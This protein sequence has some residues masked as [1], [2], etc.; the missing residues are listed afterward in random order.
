MEDRLKVSNSI[1]FSL[2]DFPISSNDAN[3]PHSTYIHVTVTLNEVCCKM[4][5]YLHTIYI[6]K[7]FDDDHFL[8]FLK[9]A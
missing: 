6:G 3:L 9:S 5:Y 2:T 4:F 8:W 7:I 1:S